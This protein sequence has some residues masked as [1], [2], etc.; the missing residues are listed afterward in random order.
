MVDAAQNNPN[1]LFTGKTVEEIALI[2]QKLRNDIERKKEDL[3]QMVGERYRDLIE[4][5]DTITMMKHHSRSIKESIGNLRELQTK[6]KAADVKKRQNETNVDI[7]Y[8]ATAATIRFLTTLPERIIQLLDENNVL[9]AGQCF[10]IGSKVKSSL[11]QDSRA[12]GILVMV[13]IL[14]S[15]LVKLDDLRT[16]IIAAAK[17]ALKSADLSAN[18][19]VTALLTI[20]S[21]KNEADFDFLAEF[22]N[23]R[24]QGL[25][26]LLKGAHID[27]DELEG[28]GKNIHNSIKLFDT[29]FLH[30]NSSPLFQSQTTS[31]SD[32]IGAKTELWPR[33][34]PKEVNIMTET[35]VDN[36]YRIPTSDKISASAN[37]LINS[38]TERLSEQLPT[39][40]DRVSSAQTLAVYRDSI[41]SSISLNARDSFASDWGNI[42]A[43]VFESDDQIEKVLFGTLTNIF[44][45]RLETI[46]ENGVQ[47]IQTNLQ[48]SMRDILSGDQHDFKAGIEDFIWNDGNNQDEL[49]DSE[50]A[51]KNVSLRA[52]SFD[53]FVAGLVKNCAQEFDRLSED[54]RQFTND[55]YVLKKY[56]QDF[57]ESYN[58]FAKELIETSAPHLSIYIARSC[59]TLTEMCSP[60][61]A[62]LAEEWPTIKEALIM[63]GDAGISKW[64][65]ATADM[66]AQVYSEQFPEEPDHSFLQLLPALAKQV[67]SEENESG[68]N[69]DST[70]EVPQ[71]LRCHFFK[72]GNK[73]LELKFSYPLM[74]A[75]HYQSNEIMKNGMHSLRKSQHR[76][77]VKLTSQKLA[78][79]M[80]RV[81]NRWTENGFAVNQ[82]VAL[83]LLFDSRYLSAATDSI[84]DAEI[85]ELQNTLERL[86]IF[87][88]YYNLSSTD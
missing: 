58:T 56:C 82:P 8:R 54:A 37:I 51:K 2:E 64:M 31:F 55:R 33:F 53:P 32:L 88:L 15:K 5:A 63:T 74:A 3:R 75:L 71:Y 65:E 59:Y 29:L 13:P 43:R 77:L 7:R 49:K 30:G 41:N 47:E 68:S 4:A 85:Q 86:V 36:K 62:S 61:P 20:S 17:G 40:L 84:I 10:I 70:I 45:K 27:S 1:D 44:V 79:A 73:S 76:Q 67:V 11:I 42:I 80:N 35:P 22:V 60:L 48:Q 57:V 21:L 26:S 72:K 87:K 69:V 23:C 16:N 78:I 46:I 38:I 18:D 19:A 6:A 34:L 14:K 83:Q 66:T 52:K 28:L 25:A 9:L 24:V 12:S 39:L 50:W 81:V